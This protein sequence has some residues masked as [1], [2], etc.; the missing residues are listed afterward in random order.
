VF[1][2]PDS[3]MVEP[4]AVNAL[5]VGSSPTLGAMRSQLINAALNDL[6]ARRF[7]SLTGEEVFAY[8]DLLRKVKKTKVDGTDH[9]VCSIYL[10]LDKFD[11]WIE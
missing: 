6:N 11:L 8:R 4:R 7:T 1:L 10:S 2:F 3:S 9:Y 5:V